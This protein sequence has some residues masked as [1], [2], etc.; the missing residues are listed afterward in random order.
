MN[1]QLN[2]TLEEISPVLS[3]FIKK[4]EAI[5]NAQAEVTIEKIDRQVLRAHSRIEENYKL[6]NPR[7][8][9]ICTSLSVDMYYVL[10]GSELV[11]T[12][13]EFVMKPGG[14]GV[15]M[16][17][18][19]LVFLTE[20]EHSCY[21]KHLLAKKEDSSNL[22]AIDLKAIV[23][24]D[25]LQKLPYEINSTLEWFRIRIATPKHNKS[26]AELLD[27]EVS[28]EEKIRAIEEGI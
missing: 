7:Y 25:V 8:P 21:F 11:P 10:L 9:Q 27:G 2:K 4:Q 3:Q 13:R 15:G 24:L 12:P 22:K 19:I 5:F 26:I 17:V 16:P 18:S 6:E 23:H 1:K 14:A 28:R 20:K